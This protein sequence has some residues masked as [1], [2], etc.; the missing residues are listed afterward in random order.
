VAPAGQS[1]NHQT[2]PSSALKPW[3]FHAYELRLDLTRVNV[4]RFISVEDRLADGI[5]ITTLARQRERDPN[6]VDKAYALHD[7]CYRR[8]PPV[9]LR[10]TRL[11]FKLWAWGSLDAIDALPDAYFLAVDGDRYVGLTTATLIRRLP[12]TLECRFTGV[13]PEYAG[14]GIG[15]GLKVSLIRYALKHGFR[16]LRTTVL[17]DNIAM[18]KINEGLGFERYREFVQSYPQLN[19]SRASVPLK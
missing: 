9:A 1:V 6:A 19:S 18:L 15:R 17:A 12:G 2:E 5:R 11:P 13:L 16:E 14:K 3:Q 7:E 4:E 10:Q 8:Q